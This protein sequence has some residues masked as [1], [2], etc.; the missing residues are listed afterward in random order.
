[1]ISLA[2]SV[3]DG[4]KNVLLLKVGVVLEDLVETRTRAQEIKDI[5]DPNS[6]T[7]NTG[8]SPALR[9]VD[10]DPP[11]PVGCAHSLILQPSRRG[12]IRATRRCREIRYHR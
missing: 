1:M 7:A 5:N 12:K 11:E 3:L 6:H 2:R 10:R 9:V 4:S 8:T